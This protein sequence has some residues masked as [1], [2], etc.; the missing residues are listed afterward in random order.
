VQ[1]RALQFLRDTT[2]FNLAALRESII[3]N[4]FVPFEQIVVEAYSP[5]AVP[6]LYVV[7]EGNR[8]AAAI[9]MILRDHEGGA[10][11]LTPEVLE[12]LGTV[13]VIE[14]VGTEAERSRYRLEF[15]D[16]DAFSFLIGL[17]ETGTMQFKELDTWLRHHA[18][19]VDP[20]N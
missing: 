9:T 7:V 11:T 2:S 10:L 18:V 3:S 14:I 20:F 19:P 17:Y 8:R 12:T 15:D 13:S 6:P 1:E 4:G 5:E 16:M